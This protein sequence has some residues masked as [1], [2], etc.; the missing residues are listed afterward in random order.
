MPTP[1]LL[2]SSCASSSPAWPLVVIS[3]SIFRHPA[4]PTLVQASLTD[5]A[6]VARAMVGIDV[7]IHLAATPDDLG[8]FDAP[9]GIMESNVHGS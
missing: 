2:R 6:A 3:P 5:K 9:G 7:V 4:A 8:A 1:M